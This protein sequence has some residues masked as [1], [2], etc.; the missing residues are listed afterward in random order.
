MLIKGVIEAFLS[1]IGNAT[2]SAEGAELGVFLVVR[3]AGSGMM[4]SGALA[5]ISLRHSSVSAL[6]NWWGRV[7]P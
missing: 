3:V 7:R 5:E 1:V 4:Y 2:N 6:K